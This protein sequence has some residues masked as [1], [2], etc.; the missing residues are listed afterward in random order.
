VLSANYFANAI[1][2]NNGN[3]NFTLKELPWQAQL[4]PLRDAMVMNANKD[5]KP[6]VLLAGNFYPCNIQL[7]KYDADY[8]TVLLNKGNGDFNAKML[9]GLTI[10]G[11]V[12]RIKKITIKNREAYLVARNNDSLIVL[13]FTAQ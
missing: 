7:G 3:F 12:R 11:E 13:G 5:N 9:N 2:I 6:D 8:G 4:M 1:L 10:K